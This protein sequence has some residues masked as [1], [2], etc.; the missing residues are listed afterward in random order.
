MGIRTAKPDV[1][2]RRKKY[3]VTEDGLLV[4]QGEVFFDRRGNV[5]DG[6][7]VCINRQDNVRF[8][9]Q[10]RAYSGSGKLVGGIHTNGN[11]LVKD[12][13]EDTGLIPLPEVDVTEDDADTDVPLDSEP[14]EDDEFDLS[15]PE[16]NPLAGELTDAVNQDASDLLDA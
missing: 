16:G 2:D 13:P 1:F 4:K 7:A 12:V 8:I 11:V 14:D 10:G 15:I 9:Y 6:V 5:V 3:M